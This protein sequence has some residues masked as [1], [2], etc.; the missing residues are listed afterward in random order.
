M[1]LGK[2]LHLGQWNGLYKY[3]TRKIE[4][5]PTNKE[6]LCWF[7]SFFVNIF[8][9]FLVYCDFNY[10]ICVSP[11]FRGNGEGTIPSDSI[12]LDI[13]QT[14]CYLASLVWYLQTVFSFFY[15][16]WQ[17]WFRASRCPKVILRISSSSLLCNGMNCGWRKNSFPTSKYIPGTTFCWIHLPFFRAGCEQG[18]WKMLGKQGLMFLDLTWLSWA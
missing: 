2:Y 17:G 8:L 6:V 7:L 12:F 10:S 9:I 14:G 16:T 11:E 15:T 5:K 3:R 13:P 18:T 1:N 4:I